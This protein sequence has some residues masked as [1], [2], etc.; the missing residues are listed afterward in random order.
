MP[1]RGFEGLIWETVY[2]VI[3]LSALGKICCLRFPVLLFF[4]G[5]MQ[6][7]KK[8]NSEDILPLWDPNQSAGQLDNQILDLTL[9]P[10]LDKALAP[11]VFKVAGT[12]C[13]HRTHAD[14]MLTLSGG[15]RSMSGTW[16]PL[17]QFGEG[18]RKKPWV[19]EEAEMAE[20]LLSA[21]GHFLRT[22]VTTPLAPVTD[23]ERTPQ[24]TSPAQIFPTSSSLSL[25]LPWPS[26]THVPSSNKAVLAPRGLFIL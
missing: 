3:N 4:T 21:S 1:S 11:F 16:S 25:A 8:I 18:F 10:G 22:L 6:K 23:T 19:A 15:A 12:W 7:L 9:F 5:K 2:S 20:C 26:P 14:E 13:R 24:F 17:W